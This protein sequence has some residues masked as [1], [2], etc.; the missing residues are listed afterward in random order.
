[1]QDFSPVKD[2][3]C[4]ISALSIGTEVYSEIFCTRL[5]AEI[6]HLLLSY[7]QKQLRWVGVRKSRLLADLDR[8]RERFVIY[9]RRMAERRRLEIRH[10]SRIFWWQLLY[11]VTFGTIE[12]LW[13]EPV[14]FLPEY[15][16][17][18]YTVV[19]L[20]GTYLQEGL[21][22]LEIHKQIHIEG[23]GEDVV[24]YPTVQLIQCLQKSC[25]NG[26]YGDDY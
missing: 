21:N 10:Q 14:L 8:E 2:I 4:D 23:R 12:Y 19:V 25:R 20:D 9:Q 13:H 7:S 18:I 3:L 15:I 6:A 1:M 16:E 24:I 22:L 17:P 11:F 5:Q 26:N